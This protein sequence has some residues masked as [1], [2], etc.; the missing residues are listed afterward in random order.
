MK[1]SRLNKIYA[2]TSIVFLISLAVSP[3]KDYFREWR[4]IQNNFNETIEKL[5]Q[6][7]KPV[8]IGL[9]QIWVRDLDRIDRC[10]TCHLGIDNIK[11]KTAPQ[12]FKLHSKVYHDV[13]KFGC[14]ICHEGQGL[15]T[16]YDEV[17]LPTEFWDRPLL[18]K[19]YI[20]SSCG[21]CHIN[22][23]LTST[24]S[25]NLGK[26]LITDLSCSGCHNKPGIRKNFTPSLDGIGRKVIGRN[27]VL[28][29]L[30][31]PLQYQ[32]NTKM[33][34]FVLSDQETD[35][36]TDFL[37]SFKTFINGET[38]EPLPNI[39]FK[40]KD[41]EDF[42]ALGQ[43]RF[44]EARCISCH[45]IEGKGGKLATDLS[46]IA[47]KAKE[48]WIYNYIKNP[49]KFQPQVEMPQYGFSDEEAAAIT[50]YMK[51][52]FI[53]WDASEEDTTGHTPLPD[54][55]EKGLALFNKYNCGGCHRLSAKGIIENLGPDLA[56][57]GSK[58]TYQIDWGE[59]EI[60]HTIYDFIENKIN[61]PREFGEN[62]RMPHYSLA[63]YQTEAIT[64]YLLSLKEESLPEN[65]IQRADEKPERLMQGEVGRIFKKYAC[66]KCHSLNSSGGDVAPDLTTVGSQLK[67]EWMRDYFKLPYTL[68]P[69][70][71]ERM[72]NLFISNNE[73]EILLNYFNNVLLDDSLQTPVN[74]V[75]NKE[76]EERGGS[77]FYE[78]YGCQ[79]CHIVGGKGGYVG[80]P[81]D[82]IGSRLKP[83]WIYNW[84]MNPQKYKPET[85]EPRTGM[86]VQDASD[87][88]AFLMSL[89]K[90]GQL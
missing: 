51:S 82:N 72:P 30:K 80:P 2:V 89:K 57:V 20:E 47:S 11:L 62:T 56:T 71:E 45:A 9:Q 22:T 73:V 17:H 4:H 42:I 25:L 65:Y 59:T 37:M 18:P 54:F 84:L 81:L 46:K 23:N 29:W 86:P 28:N 35:I 77:L 21:R 48:D 74:M 50:A 14:T 83:G 12:P 76:S 1:L 78:K 10:T 39:Y 55:Y 66:L 70:V 61:N 67:T 88:T 33:P 44:A 7:V 58:R 85:I 31:D 27:W 63:R 15:A 34:N 3:L 38:L 53:D 75:I 87:I 90:S 64:T 60:P 5:P 43:T 68:R 69:I 41:N 6:K 8:S 26:K 16:D 36:L 49:R 13:E 32:P 24:P 40:N 79:S 52:E 19:K